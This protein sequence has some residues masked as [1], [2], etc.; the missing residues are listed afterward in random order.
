MANITQRARIFP[1]MDGLITAG[2]P[3]G[4]SAASMM[5]CDNVVLDVKYGKMK[6]PGISTLCTGGLENMSTPRCAF[7]FWRATGTAMQR[8]LV[9]A[10]GGRVYGDNG[11]GLFT[12]ITGSAGYAEDSK[13]S[14]DA[15]VG[16]LIICSNDVVPKTWNQT[17][18]IATLAGTPPTAKF[19]R[20]WRRYTFFG[21]AIAAPHRLYPST[22]P[23]DPTSGYTHSMDIDGGDSDPVGLTGIFPGINEML[24]I[25]KRNSLYALYSTGDYT[26]PF[27]YNPIDASHGLLNHNCSVAI[28]GDVIYASDVGIHSLRATMQYGD[29]QAAFLSAPISNIWQD[30]VDFTYADTFSMMY[31]SG[32]NSVMLA[33][34]EYE[35][36]CNNILLIYNLEL[37]QWTMCKS[38]DA[39]HLF[40]Y[41]DSTYSR[42]AA[43]LTSTGRIGMFDDTA[44][45][46]FGIT[47]GAFIK[48]PVLIPTAADIL[49]TFISVTLFYCPTTGSDKINC[50]YTIDTEEIE[51]VEIGMKS[52]SRIGHCKIGDAVIGLN[53]DVDWAR[54]TFPIKGSGTSI[55]FTFHQDAGDSNFAIL[56]YILEYEVNEDD[57][58]DLT[59]RGT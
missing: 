47:V 52:G 9:A 50:T 57:V 2:I 40:K 6:R 42:R 18:N 19:V 23:D 59:M 55:Q 28:P 5:D 56:G 54:T 4:T 53:G 1:A 17:G 26:F 32:T 49:H 27:G 21:G 36:L 16:E 41:T 8:R 10:G 14:M 35:S 46:D 7:D 20:F 51:T 24:V 43:L 34:R 31:D 29:M 15:Y 25:G 33:C 13:F 44:T 39:N 3:G 37:K 45:S 22:M 11:S 38:F 58:R 48:S 30:N 12:D